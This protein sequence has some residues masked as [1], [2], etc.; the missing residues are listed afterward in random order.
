MQSNLMEQYEFSTG[1]LSW[2]QERQ[3]QDYLAQGQVYT[4]IRQEGLRAFF[5]KRKLH[6]LLM[7]SALQGKCE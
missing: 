4:L 1:W 5:F 2:A 3:M 6:D 7:E